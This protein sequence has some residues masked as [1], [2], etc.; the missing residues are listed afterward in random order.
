MCFFCFNKPRAGAE[1]Q[2][3]SNRQGRMW[4]VGLRV[5]M[6]V[7][8]IV[9]VG[10][11][12]WLITN[13]PSTRLGFYFWYLEYEEAVDGALAA[14]CD[15]SWMRIWICADNYTAMHFIRMVLVLHCHSLSTQTSSSYSSW[16][17]CRSRPHLVWCLHNS[18]PIYPWRSHQY[19]RFWVKAISLRSFVS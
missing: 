2:Q 11:A 18:W 1:Q 12:S 3:C 16:R 6:C 19:N 9:A 10:C 17:G 13:I 5:F 15:S 7:L 8:N 14:V 4:N